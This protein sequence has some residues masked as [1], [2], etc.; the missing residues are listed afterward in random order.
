MGWQCGA[1]NGQLRWPAAIQQMSA[2][3]PDCLAL[4]LLWPHCLCLCL[5]PVSLVR[6]PRQCDH[7]MGSMKCQRQPSNRLT[8]SAQGSLGSER[9]LSLEPLLISECMCVRGT[10]KRAG[11]PT[12]GPNA[13]CT[14]LGGCDSPIRANKSKPAVATMRGAVNANICRSSVPAWPLEQLVVTIGC[15]V[16]RL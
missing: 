6:M 12:A 3:L 9:V 4:Q 8:Y 11:R 1:F 16:G 10:N 13:H 7:S 5:F 15:L 2:R 14:L